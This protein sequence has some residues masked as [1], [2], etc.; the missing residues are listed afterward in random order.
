MSIYI[1]DTGVRTTHE[2]FEDRA[3]FVYDAVEGA[4]VRNAMLSAIFLVCIINK[5][6]YCSHSLRVT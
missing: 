5:K 4:V 2:E 3:K 1:I 6:C